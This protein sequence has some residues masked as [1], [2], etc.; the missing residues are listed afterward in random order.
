MGSLPH[1]E[2]P[3]LTL[4]EVI[5]RRAET[6]AGQT[7]LSYPATDSDFVHY[8]GADLDRLTRL[9]AHHYAE[10][11]AQLDE[12]TRPNGPS[13]T[14]ALVGVSSLDYYI[15]FL[16]LQR[17]GL[18]TMFI[19]P[20]LADQ[21]FTHLLTSTHCTAVI[22]SGPSQADM[23][24]IRSLSSP[25]LTFALIPLH[26]ITT[27]PSPSALPPK[28]LP[29]CIPDPAHPQRFI[30]HSGGTTGLPKPVPLVARSWLAQAAAIAARMPRA[31]T[32]STLP[33]FHSFGLATL[34]RC[35]AA[36]SPLAL[37]SAARPVTAGAVLDALD[38]T[39]AGALVTVPYVLKFLGEANDEGEGGKGAGGVF[40]RLARLQQVVA[41]G[42]AVPDALGDALVVGAGVRLFHLYGLTE[43]G[44]LMEPSRVAPEL[45]NW[46]TPLPD[47]AP[48]L[49]FER[50]GEEGE[51]GEGG[52]NVLSDDASGRYATKDLFRR[53]P[54]LPNHWKFAA[55]LDDIVVLV[56]GEKADPVPLE[57]AVTKSPL[58]A[59]AVVF[60]AGR[61]ALGMVI[62]ASERA[63][64][65]SGDEVVRGILPDLQRGNQGVPA[66][67][68]V[69]EEAVLVMAAGTKWPCTDKGTV[70]RKAFLRQFEGEI[71]AF[72]ARREE[73]RSGAEGEGDEVGPL[74]DAGV[75]DLVRRTVRG[76][77]RLAER[78]VALAD[79]S[80][81]F[82]L[83][84]D[85]LQATNV[86]SRLLKGVSLGGRGLATNVVFD[87]PSVELLTTHLLEVR[88][89]QENEQQ[90]AHDLAMR[91][92]EKYTTFDQPPP[93]PSTATP[94]EQES[95]LLTG[96]TGALGIHILSTLLPNPAIRTI[97][98]LVRASD[99][100]TALSRI[101]AAL[102][103]SHIHPTPS[104]LSK[105]AAIP[106]DLSSP[107]GGL[108]SLP[109][110]TL[111]AITATTTRVIHAAWSVDFNRSLRS[112]DAACLAPMHA[113][114]ALT[115]ATAA[116]GSGKG[117]RTRPPVFV[118]V[119]S[120]AAALRA[121]NASSTSTPSSSPPP[122]SPSTSSSSPTPGENPILESLHPWTAVA[123][124]M[125]YGQSKWVAE[126][127][128]VAAALPPA[129]P[130]STG[131]TRGG[132]GLHTRILRVG[133]LCGDT[134]H[135]VWN[136]SEAVPATVRAAL[137]IGALPF[138]DGDGGDEELSWLPVDVA[139]SAVVELAFAE[140]E[141]ETEEEKGECK[142]WH[143]ENEQRVRWNAEFL[144][145][146]RK[147]G[148]VFDAVPQ[149]EW[150]GRLERGE[151][152]GER[153]PAVKLLEFFRKRYGGDGGGGGE[154]AHPVFDMTQ[155]KRF[156]PSLRGGTVVDEELV[157]K[158]LRFW[159]GEWS[160]SV[161][162]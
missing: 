6:H 49:E 5:R 86:R 66:Y 155:A 92:L 91:L 20:R 103:R 40:E 59:A 125:G 107:D 146:L 30:I 67:A 42:S 157:G 118:F 144:P 33:L 102:S 2:Q 114:L 28:P 44:A 101:T 77:L 141:T 117:G 26:P 78:G 43:C 81:F 82:A 29:P 139:A 75:R 17:L 1:A 22:A 128:C 54:S 131:R 160:D 151:Q 76:E 9:A 63:A 108:A 70:V 60:G 23:S 140:T 112:F 153:N 79:D 50:V 105:I 85:S 3:C 100:S 11:F 38:A 65:W 156:A 84:M 104:Q 12:E 126:Q 14:V 62:V 45:W 137:S 97:H 73:A 95:V 133:Q 98:C 152:D 120:I 15:T 119:S 113:L 46:V 58:V 74:D 71:E 55:R 106:C 110:T 123:D 149:R 72:Y 34:L 83:G 68:R 69:A 48:F 90:S 31:A 89:G 64:G 25:S 161:G 52:G 111:A 61:D 122:S 39:D 16:A 145:A 142:V 8:T 41:A 136:P 36:G 148:L 87:H 96:A 10:A 32:L 150:V 116:A 109:S 134:R 115:A 53:H 18:S 127:M 93:A 24:R 94:P 7:L 159:M 129:P 154:K 21:G 138:V 57:V 88:A 162:K 132:L 143:V 130:P 35:L 19:S 80:D 135:G 158:F 4:D 27:S 37:L 51:D 47:A 147:A 121:G 124:G 13:S 99:A 56:N